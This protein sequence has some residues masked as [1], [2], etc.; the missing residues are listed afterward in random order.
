MILRSLRV[1]GWRCFA[2]P[3]EIGPLSEGLNVVH[4]PNGS[5]KSTLLWALA[6]G[7]FDPYGSSA[8]DIKSIRPW[9]RSLSPRIEIEFQH[10]DVDYQV[11]KQFLENPQTCLYRREGGQFTPLAEGKSADESLRELLKSDAPSKRKSRSTNHWGFAQVLWATQGSLQ[12]EELS[13]GT[14]NT[15]HDSLGA[16]LAGPG[17]EEIEQ[18]VAKRYNEIFTPTGK[19]KG[20]ASAPP[21]VKLQE[22]YESLIQ[23]RAELTERLTLFDEASRRIEDLRN[24]Q[25]QAEQQAGGLEEDVQAALEVASRFD[26]LTGQCEALQEKEKNARNAHD[27]LKAKVEQITQ[28]GERKKTLREALRELEDKAADVQQLWQTCNEEVEAAKAALDT[29][30]KQREASDQAERLARQAMKFVDAARNVDQAKKR[31][32]DVEQSTAKVEEL[33]HATSELIAPDAAALKKIRAAARRRDDTRLQLEATLIR[34][35]ISPLTKL[36]I[37]VQQAERTGRQTGES[38]QVLEIQGAPEVAFEIANVASI[39]ATGP[40][41]S[42]DALRDE[43]RQAESDLEQLTAGFGTQDVVQLESLLEQSR[44][45][46]GDLREAKAR[47]KTLLGNNTLADLQTARNKLQAILDETLSA[48]PSWQQSPPDAATLERDAQEMKETVEREI[49]LTE[50]RGEAAREAL[51]EAT[52]AKADLDGDLKTVRQQLQEVTG[53]LETAEA[54]GL[55]DPQRQQQLDDAALEW[56]AEKANLKSKSDEL[57]ALGDDPHAAVKTLQEQRKSLLDQATQSK[58]KLIRAEAQLQAIINEAPYS[59]LSKVEEQIDQLEQEMAREKL[60]YDAIHLLHQTF[61]EQTRQAH[62]AVIEPV[63]QRANR[64]L[65][66]IAGGRFQR[67]DFNDSLLPTGVRPAIAEESVALDYLSGG[68]QEQVH[69]AVRLALAD[70]AFGEQRQLL[71]LDDAFT[72]TDT[73]RLARIIN[74]LQETAQRCQVLLLS[75]HPDR[76]RHLQNVNFFDLQQ[77]A[78]PALVEAV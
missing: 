7:L 43:L 1:Q 12:I 50:K 40:T 19:L 64:T 36:E 5:G 30:R 25:F 3:V 18:H 62:E 48:Q 55:D 29:S 69:F 24:E 21:L 22:D 42:A 34:V 76:Y 78:A 20:G 51:T 57:A 49:G 61:V 58:E 13:D 71:V 73:A 31:I 11:H 33:N 68:E 60:S 39:R 23:R 28:L 59:V 17:G 53:R 46:S 16:Q 72:A 56:R 15:I 2:D 10:N 4:G 65:Q 70:V 66:R 26:K 37:D 9:G 38:G 74:I 41:E 54:D 14:R 77:L 75:C 32:S 8:A 47:L 45:L 67:I 44:T 6:R 52:Q 35:T 27:Q 63:Q